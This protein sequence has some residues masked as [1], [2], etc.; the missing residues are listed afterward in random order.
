MNPSPNQSSLQQLG[1]RL[2]QIGRQLQQLWKT[3]PWL[4]K[5]VR[6]GSMAFAT[7]MVLTLVIW[8]LFR[9][10]ILQWGWKKAQDKLAHKGYSL[11]SKEIGFSGL[12][13]VQLQQVSLQA[14]QP[15]EAEF[16][17]SLGRFNDTLFAQ[18]KQ[19]QLFACKSLE[20][21]INL[22][23]FWNIGL[24]SFATENLDVQ[25]I[26]LKNYSNYAGLSSSDNP[27]ENTKSDKKDPVVALFQSLEKWV[28]KSPNRVSMNHSEFSLW[29]TTGKSSVGIPKIEFNGNDIVVQ[30]KATKTAKV[31]KSHLLPGKR[32]LKGKEDTVVNKELAFQIVGEIDKDDLTGEIEILPLSADRKIVS[33][34]L[35]LNGLGFKKGSFEVKKLAESNGEVVASLTGGF[36]GLQVNDGRIS[37]TLVVIDTASGHFDVALQSNQF[38]LDSSSFFQLNQI[39][40]NVFAQWKNGKH[41]F[42]AVGVHMP[43]LQATSFFSSLP[44]GLF[45]NIGIPKA[46]GSLSYRLKLELNDEHPEDVVLESGMWSSKDFKIIEWGNLDPRKINGDFE[47][48]FYENGKEITRFNVGE[49]NGRFVPYGSISPK[50]VTAVLKAEDPD[51]YHHQGFYVDAFRMSIAKNYKLKRFAQ[52]GS[53]ISMQLVKNVFLGRRKTIAR[54]LEEILFTWLIEKQHAVSKQRMLEV[55]LNIIEWG[56][57]IFGAHE[58][59]SFYFGKHP[60]E[61]NW[62]ESAF[63]AGIIPRPK[64]VTWMLDSVGCVRSNWGKYKS[65]GRRII[66]KDSGSIDTMEFKVCILPSAFQK[67]KGNRKSKDTVAVPE[68]REFVFPFVPKGFRKNEDLDDFN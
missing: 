29:D 41:P 28:G 36:Q 47:Y 52:G 68:V 23:K 45:R 14:P 22:L 8:F 67:L 64:K 19:E 51:F 37:D 30:V 42:Y 33:I 15:T 46:T 31:K 17:D 4:R 5:I 10:P 34:P 1:N 63:L 3:K 6:I 25:L 16:T 65:L 35:V 38:E 62:G 18:V 21:G 44:A 13:T 56:P 26:N 59:A 49:S 55:Y 50:L 9:G 54:K 32:N 48:A 58:A 66:G 20:I 7:F 12:F 53:T 40:A 24:A 39:K 43:E 11:T 2:K 27:K 57:G 60:S 61:L